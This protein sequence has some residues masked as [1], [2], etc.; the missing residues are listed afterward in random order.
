L[1]WVWFS[2]KSICCYWL[3]LYIDNISF[4]VQ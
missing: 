4:S 1:I 3:P 2:P